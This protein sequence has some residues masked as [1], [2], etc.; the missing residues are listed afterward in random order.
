MTET[1]ENLLEKNTI[2]IVGDIDGET[3][4]YVRKAIMR[5]MA[6]GCPPVEIYISSN[7]GSVDY[8]LD[9][10]DMFK[11]YK[12]EKTG[13]VIGIASSMA[14]VILQACEKR[15][16]TAHADI[17]IHHISKGDIKLDVLRDKTRLDEA[18]KSMEEN[19]LFIYKILGVKTGK[20]IQA[21]K[22]ECA[23][24][25]SMTAEAALAFGL[26]DQII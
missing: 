14:A 20:D 13:I 21:I 11:L 10:Y 23:K 1:Q 18:I 12:G 17:L 26:I 25:E 19:Q 22:E 2:D 6:K 24:D 8:G 7:G 5:L 16:A 9:I 15:K 4:F 3:A